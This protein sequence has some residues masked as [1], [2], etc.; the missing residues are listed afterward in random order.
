[1]RRFRTWL[2]PGTAMG[3]LALV[4]ALGG[5]AP[6][7]DGPPAP[8]RQEEEEPRDHERHGQEDRRRRDQEAGATLSVKSATSAPRPRRRR[9]ATTAKIAGNVY[10]ANVQA[11]G[12]MIGSIPAG[13]T[14]SKT[15]L[16]TYSVSF[17]RSITGCTISAAAAN[18]TG[19]HVAF[20]AVGVIDADTLDVFTRDPTNT[21]VDEPFYVQAICPPSSGRLPPARPGAAASGLAGLGKRRRDRTTRSARARG[22]RA[23][24]SA[25]RSPRAGRDRPSRCHLVSP[26]LWN[27]ST[28]TRLTLPSVTAVSATRSISSRRVG[29]AGHE[30]VAKPDRLRRAASRQANS[31]V[32]A[33]GRPVS[34]RCISSVP[35][36]MS[37]STRSVA[38]SRA[39]SARRPRKPECRAP[40][41]ARCS[42]AASSSA[43]REL[44]L[45]QRLAAGQRQPT[46]RQVD[47]RL[48][49]AHQRLE[50]VGA[51]WRAGAPLPG[52]GVLA[53]E[54]AQ[55]A[56]ASGRPRAA[57]PDRRRRSTG[58]TSGRSP[59]PLTT[60]A[61]G[62][63]SG[64][65]RAPPRHSP[66][67][68]VRLI[69]SI[70][71]S[72]VSRTKFTA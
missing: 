23:R 9:S 25:R 38:S 32:G 70:C 34:V 69:T 8:G 72:R 1:M 17:G 57:C 12:T 42:C 28:S 11:D 16:G 10:S 67:W 20:T 51:E 15:A 13:A 61:V 7:R 26:S 63:R 6:C 68:N 22:A 36:L 50:L 45:L 54:A 46:A 52:V 33:S 44:R 37:S 41:A 30:H 56:A 43:P 24:A 21:V 58:P 19:P 2:S 64:A 47:E 18:N 65:S 3:F 31:S 55:R 62:T 59:S 4:I 29:V 14:S 27:G 71:C 53:V 66:P 35:A 48:V 60:A 5:S 49:A 40:C 39:S